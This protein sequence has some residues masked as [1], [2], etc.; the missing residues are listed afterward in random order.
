MPIGKMPTGKMPTGKMP[1]GKMP[2]G[3]MPTVSFFEIQTK[4]LHWKDNNKIVR[5]SISHKK[6]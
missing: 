6:Y 1:I 3:K 5:L 2:I 4:K